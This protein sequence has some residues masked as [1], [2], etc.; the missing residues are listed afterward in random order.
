MFFVL[1]AAGLVSCSSRSLAR[2]ERLVSSVASDVE[3]DGIWMSGINGNTSGGSGRNR[4]LV[5]PHHGG[6]VEGDRAALVL[7]SFVCAI[8]SFPLSPGS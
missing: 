4:W 8:L 7:I 2:R 6:R 5:R 3:V 1:S